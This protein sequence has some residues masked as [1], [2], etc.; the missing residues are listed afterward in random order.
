MLG[1]N[2]SSICEPF[3][4][5]SV[6]TTS[7][8]GAHSLDS[9]AQRP[10]CACPIRTRLPRGRTVVLGP[11]SDDGAGNWSQPRPHVRQVGGANRIAGIEV[12][13]DEAENLVH[14]F[15]QRGLTQLLLAVVAWAIIAWY[16]L[17]VPAA[18]LLQLADRG[19]RSVIGKFKPLIVDGTPPG[20]IGNIIFVPILAVALWFSLPRTNA[21]ASDTR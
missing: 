7:R 17:L 1:S 3:D 12:S 14:L 19:L 8:Y 18:P 6:L 10:L 2:Q 16:R 11:G 21:S 5:S 20:V 13:G 15:V 9:H 4:A